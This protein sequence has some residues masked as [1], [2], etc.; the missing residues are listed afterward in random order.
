MF[1]AS[2]IHSFIFL[3][4]RACRQLQASTSA[5][6]VQRDFADT[7]ADASASPE[8]SQGANNKWPLACLFS[9]GGRW[10]RN[11]WAVKSLHKRNDQL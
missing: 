1:L 2:Q 7:V 5:E 6:A 10:I 8:A 4:T 9:S 11:T 3:C